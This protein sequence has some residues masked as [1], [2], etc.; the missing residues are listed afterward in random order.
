MNQHQTAMGIARM[1]FLLSLSLTAACATV[2][3]APVEEQA[4]PQAPETGLEAEPPAP[5]PAP[6]APPAVAPVTPQASVTVTTIPL[7][8]GKITP[9]QKYVNVRPEPSTGKKPV[10]VLSGG[11]YVEVL[12]REGTWVKIRWTRG[13]KAH[14]GWVAG[15]FVDTVTP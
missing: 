9:R 10:A 12:G 4:G 11:K 3:T 6:A 13:K 14:E 5:V 15:K 8:P 1:A 7:V 2:N